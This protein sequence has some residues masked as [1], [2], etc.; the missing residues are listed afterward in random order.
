MPRKVRQISKAEV[1]ERLE[2]VELLMASCVQSLTI[3]RKLQHKWGVSRRQV[4]WYMQRVRERWAN[5]SSK[6]DREERRRELETTIRSAI[7]AATARGE[8]A[9]VL[10][11]SDQLAKLHGLYEPDRV[12]T[13]HEVTSGPL[14]QVTVEDAR[15]L[16]R[17][18]GEK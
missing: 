11:G 17:E 4:R 16:A 5:E 15:K 8:P 6:L 2:E 13:K 14:L 1:A 10:R 18:G 3:E 7:A 9:Q 12:E